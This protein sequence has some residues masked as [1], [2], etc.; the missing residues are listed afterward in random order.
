MFTLLNVLQ[1][2]GLQ[3]AHQQQKLK[4]K[5]MGCVGVHNDRQSQDDVMC[6]WVVKMQS[7]AHVSYAVQRL[8]R[9]SA[10]RL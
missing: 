4:G 6:P 1:P 10:E 5:V 7:A 3:T 9:S 8:L 2:T